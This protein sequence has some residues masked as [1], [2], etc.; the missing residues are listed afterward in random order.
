MAKDKCKT[1]KVVSSSPCARCENPSYR[2]GGRR[3]YGQCRYGEDLSGPGERIFRY[4]PCVRSALRRVAKLERLIAG[5]WD[6]SN[7]RPVWEKIEQ[8]LHA[9]A[10]RIARRRDGKRG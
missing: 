1:K 4:P 6:T 10:A 9:E 7:P 8:Q 5:R 2:I 3:E